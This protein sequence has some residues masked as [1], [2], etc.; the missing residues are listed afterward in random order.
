MKKK[1]RSLEDIRE[2]KL[3]LKEK[4]EQ[5]ENFLKL[6]IDELKNSYQKQ[7][8]G[9]LFQAGMRFVL[10]LVFKNYYLAKSLDAYKLFKRLRR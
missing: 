5:N 2:A 8:S 4:L 7:F 9:Y 6:D 1:L 10:K 3:N